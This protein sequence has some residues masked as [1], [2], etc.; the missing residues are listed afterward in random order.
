MKKSILYRISCVFVG[1]F[2]IYALSASIYMIDGLTGTGWFVAA[3]ITGV[4]YGVDGYAK[5]KIKTDDNHWLD[6][7]T[8]DS[9][10][11]LD[12]LTEKL[13]KSEFNVADER[14]RLNKEAEANEW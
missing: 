6:E 12:A 5:H 11:Y 14:E 8:G 2:T 1:L 13:R 10:S 9:T 4:M 7:I 3:L